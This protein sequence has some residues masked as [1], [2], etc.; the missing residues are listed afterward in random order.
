[1]FCSFCK[2]KIHLLL[3]FWICLVL[4]VCSYVAIIGVGIAD[5]LYIHILV[6]VWTAGGFR[7]QLMIPVVRKYLGNLSHL[8]LLHIT[9]CIQDNCTCLFIPP[10]F[11]IINYCLASDRVCSSD[12]H[13]FS[14]VDWYYYSVV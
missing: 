2:K 11:I 14:F 10:L 4:D 9:V 8:C 1:V 12:C 7:T 6:C 3:L 5:A 13:C